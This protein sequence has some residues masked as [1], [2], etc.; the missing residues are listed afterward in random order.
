[1]RYV[2]NF[3]LKIIYIRNHFN[4]NIKTKT[5]PII[6]IVLGSI[7]KGF[8]LLTVSNKGFVTSD[9]APPVLSITPDTASLVEPTTS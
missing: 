8:K 2:I 4:N 3:F 7:F 9:T 1:M 6:I 5:P